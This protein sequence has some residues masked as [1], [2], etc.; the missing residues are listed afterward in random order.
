V[1]GAIGGVLFIVFWLRM[2]GMSARVIPMFLFGA[3]VVFLGL[4]RIVAEGGVGFCRAQMVPPPFVVYGLGTELLDTSTLVGMGFTYAWST[5]IRTTVMASSING[6][7]LIDTLGIRKRPLMW[8]IFLA[9]LVSMIG[10]IWITLKLAYTYGGINL[11]RWFFGGLP[12]T[13]FDFVAD[14]LRNPVTPDIVWP[15]WFFTGI[16]A[17]VMALLMF[18]RHRFTWWPLHYLGFPIGD[19]WVMEWVWFSI[20]LGWLLKVLVLRYGGIR[21]YRR[22]KPLFLGLILGQISCAGMWMVVDFITGTS[23]NYIYIGVP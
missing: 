22:L 17:A 1:W 2:S 8:A 16:G 4:A 5:D 3:F 10:S 11:Q 21:P 9:V 6:F 15:R 20:L 23:G 12:R 14:K 18:A 7:K 13:A 19:T